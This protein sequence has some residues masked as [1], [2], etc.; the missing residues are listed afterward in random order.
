MA[1]AAQVQIVATDECSSKHMHNHRN[2]E[3]SI[4]DD[5]LRLEKTQELGIY[6]NTGT[7]PR[8]I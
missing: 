6:Y 7:N 1:W 5:K 4:L 2:R 8:G 3:N